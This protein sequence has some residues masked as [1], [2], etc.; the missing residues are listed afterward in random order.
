V[1]VMDNHRAA[2]WC[3][4]QNIDPRQP[5]SLFHMD[6]HYDTL[7]SRMEAW[8]ENLPVDWRLGIDDYLSR[9]VKHRDIPQP[10]PLFCWDN[11]LSIFLAVFGGAL[12]T[13]RFAT[14]GAGTV[15][16]CTRM[17]C[18]LW[19]VPFNLDY[20]LKESRAP[21]IF[22][23]DLDYFFWHG[24]GD[25]PPQHMISEAYISNTM[26]TLSAHL[27]GGTIGV[28]TIALSPECCGGWEQ[29]EQILDMVLKPLGIEFR[30]PRT[31]VFDD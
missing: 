10:L 18:D 13:A 29:S 21:W 26:K 1:Y 3:W 20:W 2:L 15:P 22:N 7:T 9:T 12:D 23:L 6:Q 5:Y 30:L 24:D 11:Y 16:S 27:T 31:G 28:L 8:L 14:H 17:D 19:D 25:E 4:L